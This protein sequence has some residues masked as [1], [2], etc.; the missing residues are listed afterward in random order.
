M[1]PLPVTRSCC[2]VSRKGRNGN[3]VLPS[4]GLID[5]ALRLNKDYAI[6]RM[7]E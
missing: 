1:K 2:D 7:E 6:A 3:H 5:V 4:P